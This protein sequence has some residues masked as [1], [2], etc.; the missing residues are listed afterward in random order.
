ME[1]SPLIALQEVQ[2][3]WKADYSWRR[4]QGTGGLHLPT[5]LLDVV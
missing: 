4:L 3:P 2:S 1:L 5:R